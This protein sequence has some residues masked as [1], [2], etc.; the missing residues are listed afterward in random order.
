[1]WPRRK[2]TQLC[3]KPKS[4]K[5]QELTA[6]LQSESSRKNCFRIVRQMAR[7]GRHVIS[8]YCMKND[9]GN[10]VPDA[11]RMKNIWRKYMEKLLNVENDWDG[12]VYYP[13]VMGPC[14]LISE[15]AVASAING[16][17]IGKAA[18][19]TGV[20]SEMMKAS[21]G[22]GTRWITDLI[23]NIV[24][25]GCI[26]EDCRNSILV[27]LYKRKCDPLVCGSYR[28]IKLLQKPMRVLEKMIRCQVSTCSLAS[29]LV[30]EPLMPLSS[31]NKYKRNTK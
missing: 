5:L 2:Y 28:A 1:M 26:P 11:D 23:H 27:P 18:G 25:E 12:E 7:E 13:E 21:G 4:L 6:D 3:W 8:V 30:R 14:C 29:C 24:K 17:K 31:C 9:V 20:V 10:V 15:E 16:L 19:P 22:F